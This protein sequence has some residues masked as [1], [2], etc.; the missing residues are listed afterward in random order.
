MVQSGRGGF[1]GEHAEKIVLGICAAL[2]LFVVGFWVIGSPRGLEDISPAKIDEQIQEE[3]RRVLQQ[4]ESAET[5]SYDI[6][7]YAAQ[8][9]QAREGRFPDPR[10][11]ID[12]TSPTPPVAIPE[13]ADVPELA[14]EDLKPLP[15]PQRPKF[16]A[17]WEL[18][19]KENR[20][21]EDEVTVHVAA[22]YPWGDLVR[23]W[24]K[25][26]RNPRIPIRLV[27]LGVE[28]E[29]Q[30]MIRPGVWSE[31]RAVQFTQAA[32]GTQPDV[33][34]MP[35]VPA[36]DGSNSAEVN[37]VINQLEQVAW[38]EAILQPEYHEIYLPPLQQ[39]GSWRFHLPESEVTQ[40]AAV[41]DTQTDTT[42]RTSTVTQ[43]T[44]RADDW[45]PRGGGDDWGRPGDDWGRPGDDWGRPTAPGRY[46]PARR[47]TSTISS[48]EAER[49]TNV[50][51]LED[52]KRSGQVLV[53]FH[54]NSLE[55]ME[56]YRYRLRLRFL[57][58]LYT[59]DKEVVDPQKDSR[60]V[61]VE[62]PFSEWS[63]K[64]FIP[65]TTEFFVYGGF[66]RRG[67]ARVRIY[68]QRLGQRVEESF[69]VTAGEQIGERQEEKVIDPLTGQQAEREVP[70]DTGAL[71]V[72]CRFDREVYA[73]NGRVKPTVELVYLDRDGEL[74]SSIEYLDKDSQRL[75]E[76][77]EETEQA[78]PPPPK[79]R[80]RQ[81]QQPQRQPTRPGYRRPQP[82]R[83]DWRRP[84][85]GGDDWP[86]R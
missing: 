59:F 9:A 4:N 13:I 25:T 29:V 31:P 2:F 64:V 28:A 8:L 3:A 75:E 17:G 46:Q 14:I 24:N 76:L 78:A 49:I 11:S 30:E 53:W 79:P 68:A 58:P 63:D 51:P 83:D 10:S 61:A 12:L 66:E 60:I 21:V 45:N 6:T 47:R 37:Q 23:Q 36:Y 34:Q 54:D 62:T 74:K 27:V 40:L 15:A 80:Q 39:W 1:L 16:W 48:E 18:P 41:G 56:V 85:G 73:G 55:P 57:N 20:L 69:D 32:Y 86:Q 65:T 67:R 42:N 50:P 43:R 35:T 19:N 70:F 71:A 7:D 81:P 52:Q 84:G 77:E 26:L 82:G 5:P 72:D 44:R 38:Q 22:V 33:W